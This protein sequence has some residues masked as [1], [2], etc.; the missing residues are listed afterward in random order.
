MQ[1]AVENWAERNG[2]LSKRTKYAGKRGALDNMF[3]RDG[4]VVMIEFKNP[5][6]KGRL[7]RQQRLEI[8]SFV[9]TGTPAYVCARYDC[10]VS[11][12]TLHLL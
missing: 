4:K 2:V 6:G 5:N 10:A 9:A 7:S 11:V 3:T 1:V 8:D 12:L